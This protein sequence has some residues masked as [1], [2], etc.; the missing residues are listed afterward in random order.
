MMDKSIGLRVKQ[1]QAKRMHKN[2]RGKQRNLSVQKIL[3]DMQ[4]RDFSRPPPEVNTLVIAKEC[5]PE[6]RLTEPLT[7]Y[8]PAV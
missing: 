2:V 3:N 5:K 6:I 1:S 4:L 7:K 8:M